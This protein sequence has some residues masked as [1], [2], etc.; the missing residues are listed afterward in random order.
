MACRHYIVSLLSYGLALASLP[1][2]V[3]GLVVLQQIGVAVGRQLAVGFLFHQA[4]L[5][6]VLDF[7]YNGILHV[8]L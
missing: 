8:L 7:S 4:I 3:H 6:A 5:N 2:L 1:S